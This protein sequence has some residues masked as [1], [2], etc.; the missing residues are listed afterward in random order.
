MFLAAGAQNGSAAS[1]WT[2]QTQQPPLFQAETYEGCMDALIA[3]LGT[4]GINSPEALSAIDAFVR[5][6]SDIVQEAFKLMFALVDAASKSADS[7]VAEAAADPK[8]SAADGS[9][10]ADDFSTVPSNASSAR[11]RPPVSILLN[12][13]FGA[14]ASVACAYLPPGPLA[15]DIEALVLLIVENAPLRFSARLLDALCSPPGDAS[16]VRSKPELATAVV[17]AALR[18]LAAG[19]VSYVVGVLLSTCTYDMFD[20]NSLLETCA[21]RN[22]LGLV[23]KLIMGT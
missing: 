1:T 12:A 8:P 19:A 7:H 6:G 13:H 23:A 21:A 10:V 4:C 5:N 17:R 22:L 20:V 15:A 11:G 9:L 14:T 3:F 2:S 16:R 18:G